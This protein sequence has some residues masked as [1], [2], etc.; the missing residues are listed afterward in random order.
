MNAGSSLKFSHGSQGAYDLAVSKLARRAARMA[1][2]AAAPLIRI[3][4][5]RNGI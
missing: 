3:A 2:H 4:Q 5:E 1:Q